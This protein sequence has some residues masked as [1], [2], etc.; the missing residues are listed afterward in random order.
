MRSDTVIIAFLL[1][2]IFFS[3]GS[4]LM[5]F[6]ILHMNLSPVS[7]SFEQGSEDPSGSI[8]LFIESDQQNSASVNTGEPAHEN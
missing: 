1:L 3:I 6:Y 7:S 2:V 8:N 4:T 5:N